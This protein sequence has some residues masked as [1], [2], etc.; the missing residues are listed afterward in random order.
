MTS[1]HVAYLNVTATSRHVAS[2][3][4]YT[5]RDVTCGR[6]RDG[7]IKSFLSQFLRIFRPIIYLAFETGRN[8]FTKKQTHTLS[9]F[10]RWCINLVTVIV[11]VSSL[12]TSEGLFSDLQF[13]PH[14]SIWE[15]IEFLFVQ[16]IICKFCTSLC[17]NLFQMS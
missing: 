6:S 3:S 9:R 1:R 7:Y 15:I 5:S 11:A 17:K 8:F 14:C 13:H 16:Q 12:F 4:R 2:P 10:C